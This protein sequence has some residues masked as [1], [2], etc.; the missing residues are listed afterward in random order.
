MHTTVYSVMIPM[1]EGTVI[2]TPGIREIELR[3]LSYAELAYLF[4]DFRDLVPLCGMR[5]CRHLDEPGCAV[6][7]AVDKGGIHPGPV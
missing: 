2:D 4:R 5:N 3:G 6:R 7:A 1:E